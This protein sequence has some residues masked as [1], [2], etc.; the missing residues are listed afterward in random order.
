M[1]QMLLRTAAIVLHAV[2]NFV[3][4]SVLLNYD[5]SGSWAGFLGFVALILV[6]IY[7]FIRHLLS[8][9]YYIKTKNK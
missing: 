7:L 1:N 9:I 8:Y 3:L 5:I 4:V 2:A 6:L